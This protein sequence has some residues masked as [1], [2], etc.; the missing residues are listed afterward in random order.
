MTYVVISSSAHSGPAR[1][2]GKGDTRKN[3]VTP[4]WACVF[5]VRLATHEIASVLPVLSVGEPVRPKLPASKLRELN[6]PYLLGLFLIRTISTWTMHA[7]VDLQPDWKVLCQ[8]SA[9]FS[10]EIS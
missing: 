7:S 10:A 5:A 4:G 1:P 6:A 3:C 8:C 9:N 2:Y